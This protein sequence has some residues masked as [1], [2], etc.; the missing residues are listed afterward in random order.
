VKSVTLSSLLEDAKGFRDS[1]K[2]I[3][4]FMP[5]IYLKIGFYTSILA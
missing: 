3:L 2:K 4:G 1:A 5:M